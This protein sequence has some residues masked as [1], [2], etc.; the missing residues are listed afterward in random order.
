MLLTAAFLRVAERV[1]AMPEMR[2]WLDPVPIPGEQPFPIPADLQ[3]PVA[4]TEMAGE[5]ARALYQFGRIFKP[6]QSWPARLLQELPYLLVGQ[7]GR[8]GAV[9]DD[10][11]NDQEM[12]PIGSLT[13]AKLLQ[14]F[15]KPEAW[16]F[17]R[18]AV[19][20]GS[21][22]EFRKDYRTLSDGDST[23]ARIIYTALPA[24]ASLSDEEV[25]QV[26]A[27]MPIPEAAVLRL[28][29]AVLRDMKTEGVVSALR[30]PLEVWWGQEMQ[31]RLAERI[32][33]FLGS[34]E[35]P[36]PTRVVAVANGLPVSRRLLALVRH[37]PGLLARV[38]PAVPPAA[39]PGPADPDPA[40]ENL[41]TLTLA[42]GEAANRGVNVSD[43]AIGRKVAEIVKEQ[44]LG[45]QGAFAAM[46]KQDGMTEA[47]YLELT[48]LN[49]AYVEMSR[50][51]ERDATSPAPGAVEGANAAQPAAATGAAESAGHAAQEH[52]QAVA[53]WVRGLRDMALVYR[54]PEPPAGRGG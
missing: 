48:R 32:S 6:P 36:D 11:A 19:E 21:V 49:V 8:S 14:I 1:L 44:Y 23:F 54:I 29:L 7:A 3:H 17:A 35:P 12:G 22:E 20:H 15:K 50:L 16:R 28:S 37:N 34:G 39:S 40:L 33:A 51:I 47:E 10:L 9:L 26:T 4:S 24:L 31:P 43:E 27:N 18:R 25:G 52:R 13:A 41:V 53:V 46:L 38:P 42:L 5:L 2:A 45:D 30:L